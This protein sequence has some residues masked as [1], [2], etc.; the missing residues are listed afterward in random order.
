MKSVA[1][2]LALSGIRINGVAPGNINFS[3]STWERKIAEDPESVE[4]ML[5]ENVPLN[6]F[7]R[8]T[9]VANM[10]VWLA[11]DVANF[12]TGAVFVTDGGQTRS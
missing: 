10:V 7:G 11:S 1:R 6:R 4:T 8:P 2:P 3:G 5:K 9:D 12:V